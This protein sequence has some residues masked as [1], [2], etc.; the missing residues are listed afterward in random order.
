ME[1]KLETQ[2]TVMFEL[3]E[4]YFHEAFIYMGK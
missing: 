2:P 1:N 3:L 4:E